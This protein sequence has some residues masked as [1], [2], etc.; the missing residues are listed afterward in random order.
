MTR[1]PVKPKSPSAQTRRF[2]LIAA[3]LRLLSQGASAAS[4]GTPAVAAAA[5]LTPAQFKAA[6]PHFNDY[7]VALLQR[8][9]D[10]VREETLQALKGLP[11][12]VTRIRKGIT[13]YLDAMQQR[14]ALLELT[15]TL[16][17]MPQCQAITRTRL[18]NLQAVVSAE[19]KSA[20]V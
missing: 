8:M 5:G 10:E 3:G 4:L 20:K 19:L 13:A 11:A 14:P 9:A 12:D 17:V 15:E 1:K 2:V 6:F 18:D 7:L 16:R